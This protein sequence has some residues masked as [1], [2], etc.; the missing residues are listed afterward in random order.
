MRSQPAPINFPIEMGVFLEAIIRFQVETCRCQPEK[1]V[2]QF[3]AHHALSSKLVF[4][5]YLCHP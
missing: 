1:Q 3:A 2:R 4:S 5:A